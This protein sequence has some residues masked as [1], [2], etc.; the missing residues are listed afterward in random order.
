MAYVMGQ[1]ADYLI[2]RQP[3]YKSVRSIWGFN[4]STQV[5]RKEAFKEG[6]F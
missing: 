2:N 4:T 3:S 6:K 5:A 1:F